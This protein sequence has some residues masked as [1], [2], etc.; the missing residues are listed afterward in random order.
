M[1]NT[2]P[3]NICKNIFKNGESTTS[4]DNFTKAWIHLI[5]QLEKN[6]GCQASPA[7]SEFINKS[8]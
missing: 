5:N 7:A 1:S 4:K 2:D 3:K 8:I 6:N